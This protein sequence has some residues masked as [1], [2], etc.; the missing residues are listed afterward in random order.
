MSLNQLK[1]RIQTWKKAI[2]VREP[3]ERL[4]S[5]YNDKI[6][7]PVKD[8]MYPGFI[9]LSRE[10]VRKKAAKLLHNGHK[11]KRISFNDFLIIEVIN[12]KDNKHW[13]QYYKTCSPCTLGLDYIIKLDPAMEDT[14]VSFL[15]SLRI[16]CKYFDC[17]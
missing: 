11:T 15:F 13:R 7:A 9:A 5:C 3:M 14:K 1:E 10:K 8:H 12:G 2:V 16:H 4:A 17:T 6:L